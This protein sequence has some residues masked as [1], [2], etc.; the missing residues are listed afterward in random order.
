MHSIS[1]ATIVSEFKQML[2]S[3]S[4]VFLEHLWYPKPRNIELNKIPMSLT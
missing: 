1:I 3:I 4:Q 2:K